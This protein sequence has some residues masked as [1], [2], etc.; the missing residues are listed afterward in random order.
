MTPYIYAGL[1][2]E[3]RLKHKYQVKFINVDIVL[4][5]VSKAL[6]IDTSELVSPKRTKTLTEARCIAMNIIMSSDKT[7][8]LKKVGSYF[9]RHHAT[10]FHMRDLY[11]NLIKY[12][13]GFQRK[14]DKVKAII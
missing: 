3:D 8:T 14:V 4:E 2:K 12:D 6:K 10:V 11:N 13:R 5:S 7:I 9:N 1:H